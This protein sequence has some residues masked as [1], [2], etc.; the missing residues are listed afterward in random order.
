VEY[1]LLIAAIAAVLAA[2]LFGLGLTFTDAYHDTCIEME[3]HNPLTSQDSA[4]C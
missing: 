2:V 1:G 4:D 3:K